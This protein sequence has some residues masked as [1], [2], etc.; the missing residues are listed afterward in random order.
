MILTS[1]VSVEVVLNNGARV[2]VV[3]FVYKDLSG[4]KSGALHE[5]A[6]VQFWA[7]D[8][9]VATFIPGLPNTVAIPTI[10]YK[11]LTNGKTLILRKFLLMIYWAYTIQKSQGNTL[12]I[13]IIY[14]GKSEK[15][16]GM[17]LVALSRVNKLSHLLLRPVSLK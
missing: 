2:K 1:N 3:D 8:E 13:A 16:S 5:A 14:L 7:L 17:T 6:V 11:W 12:D 15:C 9:R 10:K 4:P